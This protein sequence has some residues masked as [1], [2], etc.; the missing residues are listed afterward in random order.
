VDEGV[1]LV[2]CHVG[3]S[4]CVHSSALLFETEKAAGRQETKASQK[5]IVSANSP[6]ADTVEPTVDRLCQRLI[7]SG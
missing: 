3:G 1:K 7:V 4:A 5:I 2:G 6:I